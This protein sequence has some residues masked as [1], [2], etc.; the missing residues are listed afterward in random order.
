[1]KTNHNDDRDNEIRKVLVMYAQ[2]TGSSAEVFDH[3]FQPVEKNDAN[4]IAH[5]I[6][7]H[8]TG[9]AHCGALHTDTMKESGSQGCSLSYQC[10]LGLTF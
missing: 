1:M 8:C 4:G 10:E 6:C 2:A 3:N 9:N 7:R 5:R